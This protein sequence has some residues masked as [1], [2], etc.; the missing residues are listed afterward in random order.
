MRGGGRSRPNM[1]PGAVISPAA[2]TGAIGAC[3]AAHHTRFNAAA[4]GQGTPLVGQCA[5]HAFAES[6]DRAA[7]AQY[8]QPVQQDPSDVA[9]V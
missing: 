5:A 2:T 4:A 3:R 6:A 9:F 1:V 8:S 7:D